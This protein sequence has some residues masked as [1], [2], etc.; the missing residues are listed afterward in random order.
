MVYSSL[1]EGILMG[2]HKFYNISLA[3]EMRL[4]NNISWSGIRPKNYASKIILSKKYSVMLI[5]YSVLN[6]QNNRGFSRVFINF[7]VDSS[8]YAP[9]VMYVDLNWP[10]GLYMHL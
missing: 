4:L 5:Y 10:A 7:S 6:V 2:L 8:S 1:H 9:F 3:P